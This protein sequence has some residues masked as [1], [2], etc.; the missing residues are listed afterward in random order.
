MSVFYSVISWLKFYKEIAIAKSNTILNNVEFWGF[1]PILCCDHLYKSPG[2]DYSNEWSHHRNQLKN[3]KIIWIKVKPTSVHF[4][5]HVVCQTHLDDNFF[6]P[7][8]F[9]LKLTWCVSAFFI[10]FS[11]IRRKI[12]SLWNPILK[13]ADIWQRH[14]LPNEC[15]LYNGGLWGNSMH[16]VGSSWSFISDYIKNLDIHN[17]NF[18]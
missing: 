16:F 17:I 1:L 14:V 7:C 6:I 10:Y 2:R 9:Q 3:E 13:M 15:D 8:Y 5:L 11:W 18:S 4:I 12:N